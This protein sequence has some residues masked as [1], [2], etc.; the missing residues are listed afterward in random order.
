M[1]LFKDLELNELM[2]GEM[3]INGE[4]WRSRTEACDTVVLRILEKVQLHLV[5]MSNDWEGKPGDY[6]ILGSREMMY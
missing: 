1:L 4:R 5:E 2:E 3:N 6:V